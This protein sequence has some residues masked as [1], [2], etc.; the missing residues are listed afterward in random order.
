[1]GSG[2]RPVSGV[3]LRLDRPTKLSGQAVAQ[4][5]VGAQNAPYVRTVGLRPGPDGRPRPALTRRERAL[6]ITEVFD[7]NVEVE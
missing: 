3:V 2:A 1:M 4:P 6:R 7:E 5:S